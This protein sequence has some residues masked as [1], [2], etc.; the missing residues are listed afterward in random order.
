MI[1]GYRLEQGDNMRKLGKKWF[2]RLRA[3][4]QRTWVKVFIL[5]CVVWVF[6]YPKRMNAL[7]M[8]IPAESTIVSYHVGAASE[9]KGLVNNPRIIG[10]MEG[11]GVK[12]AAKLKKNIGV[13][14]TIFWLT[15]RHT[16]LGFV[17]GPHT[18]RLSSLDDV[19]EGYLAGASYVGW[20]TKFM[21]LLWRIKWVPGLGRMQVT[22][23]GTRYFTFPTDEV[24]GDVFLGLDIA[25]G[26]LLASLS[27]HPDDVRNL[28]DRLHRFGPSDPP[29]R[30]F[31]DQLP[32]RLPLTAKHTF[33][34]KDERVLGGAEGLFMEVSS[35][36]NESI[37]L[38]AH[39]K[40][41]VPE[42]TA[43]RPLSVFPRSSV[44][45]EDL[46]A[47]GGVA[48]FASDARLATWVGDTVSL[49]AR[50]GV[51]VG[52]LTG[53]PF[54]GR[55]L[56]LACPAALLALPWRVD[57]EFGKWATEMSAAF[58]HDS[59]R[60]TVRTVY[61]T[62][63][64][65]S[66]LYVFPTGLE[67]IARA[68]IPDM[69]FAEQRD[70][71]LRIGTH[72]GSYTRQR[73]D[74]TQAQNGTPSVADVVAEW[75]HVYPDAVAVLRVDFPMAAKEFAHLGA[76]AKLALPFLEAKDAATNVKLLGEGVAY[77]QALTPLGQVEATLSVP[78]D[79][80]L[81]LQLGVGILYKKHR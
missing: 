53:K 32:W 73:S 51:W 23:S 70:G 15:G 5:L 58:T 65:A 31:G 4:R 77:L 54:E 11:F 14:Q 6:W 81:V 36:R 39:V 63:E 71:I 22:P 38:S 2:E 57:V 75:Q 46:P 30:A 33:W 3:V 20:K 47:A 52:T 80:E 59:G 76:I 16:V 40:V 45:G 7:F 61:R 8:A 68:S 66:T 35:L 44:V 64:G 62:G 72:Y 21:E 56:G 18:T 69:A 79:G 50:E 48:L 41:N 24:Y 60:S 49:P 26:I 25:D 42:L 74:L 17:P 34:V 1:Y 55:I 13:S 27:Y 43:L 19:A 28:A 78:E 12:D 29:A 37:H 67:K 10:V 9:W